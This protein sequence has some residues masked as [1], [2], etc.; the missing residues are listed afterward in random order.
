MTQSTNLK[1]YIRGEMKMVHE[2]TAEELTNAVATT[3]EVLAQMFAGRFPDG[4]L[5]ADMSRYADEKL[6]AEAE[7][8]E[9][10]VL[11]S[12]KVWMLTTIGCLLTV[13]E[14]YADID[15]GVPDDEQVH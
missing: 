3:A 15:K 12:V 7:M 6:A 2:C 11:E 13:A 4:D 14:S 8:S 5:A 1:S 9:A 10:E